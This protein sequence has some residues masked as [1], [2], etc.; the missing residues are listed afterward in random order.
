MLV[1]MKRLGRV[2]VALVPVMAVAY[3]GYMGWD[4]SD[5][6]VNG[7]EP[8]RDC[9]TPL[10][11]GMRYEAI[12]YDITA[13]RELAEREADRWSCG[14]P[15]AAPGD[16]LVSSDGVGLAGWY[17][18]AAVESRPDGPTVIMSHG[19]NDNKS[20]MLEQLWFFHERYN[21]VLFDYRNHGQSADSQTTQGIHEQR[22]LTAVI[23][24]LVEAKGPETIV[25]WGQSMGGHTAVNVAAADPRIDGLILDVTHSRLRVPMVNRIRDAGYPFGEVGY[26]A[27]WLGT[28]MRTGVDVF[29]EEPI[30]AIQ[31]LGERPVLLVSGGQDTTIPPSDTE[32]MRAAAAAA[33]VDVSVEVCGEAGHGHIS[34]TC[35][36][37]YQRWM[38]AFLEHVTDR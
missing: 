10:D 25:L 35:P 7:Y 5:R 15:G 6:L 32:A 38:D 9:R 36:D 13:D 29:S 18:P 22:D 11:L 37:E 8:N 3:F 30:D 28:W 1:P 2:A 21:A 12:N 20:G 4:G 31:H 34:R 23:D 14:S 33:G 26:L 24:W 17:V 19:W 16:E 27:I